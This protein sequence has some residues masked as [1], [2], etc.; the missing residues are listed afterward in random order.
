MSVLA[1]LLSGAFSCLFTC[2]F[3][4][5]RPFFVCLLVI[6]FVFSKFFCTRPVIYLL[7]Y[8]LIFSF[9]L[10]VHSLIL[11]F[12]Y[13]LFS[14]GRSGRVGH[15]IVPWKWKAGFRRLESC[16][17]CVMV[18]RRGGPKP[19]ATQSPEAWTSHSRRDDVKNLLV[20]SMFIYL[21]ISIFPSLWIFQSHIIIK[22]KFL[23]ACF[24]IL[25]LLIPVNFQCIFS[26]IYLFFSLLSLMFLRGI[27]VHRFH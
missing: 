25:I 23:W 13:S 26:I 12:I 20:M 18:G 22:K 16:C 2:L 8:S 1:S 11:S 6:I 4:V 5:D 21:S 17:C 19:Q 3:S 27:S 14:V 15:W 24:S 7:F 10:F 9:F